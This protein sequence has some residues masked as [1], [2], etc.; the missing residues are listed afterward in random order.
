MYLFSLGF[1]FCPPVNVS[2][3]LPYVR[4]REES[5]KKQSAPASASATASAKP[6]EQ[7]DEAELR[8]DKRQGRVHREV[9]VVFCFFV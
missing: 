9:L 2:S 1:L 6:V 3:K 8:S 7:K 5:D 4:I